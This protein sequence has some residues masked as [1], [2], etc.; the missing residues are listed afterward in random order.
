MW[1]LEFQQR[2]APHFHVLTSDYVPKVELSR[3][4][5]RIVGSGDEK[6]LQAGTKIQT[7]KSKKHLY[8]YLSSYI[9]KLQQKSAPA[10][11]ES[12]GRFWGASRNL[13]VFELYQKISHFY[14]LSRGIKLFR[15]WYKAHLRQFG[16]KWKWRG[17]GFT[18]LDGTQF[19][20]F[21][22]SLKAQNNYS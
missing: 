12:V 14:K 11:Y 1:V 6:H 3:V 16:I 5:F 8:S 22:F 19:I 4:W 18:A 21:L 20:K 15:R 7:I 17:L 9:N 10:E 2:G 13:L